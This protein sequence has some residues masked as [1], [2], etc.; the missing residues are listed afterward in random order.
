M[1]EVELDGNGLCLIRGKNGAGKSSVVK[2]L[3]FAF[4]GIGADD[5]VNNKVGKNTSVKVYG[6][7]GD[8]TFTVKRYRQD[9]EHKNNLYFFVNN[10][11]IAGATNTALQA[12]LES[13]L[14]FDYRSFLTITSFSS[15]MLMF[16][17][18]TDAERK[19]IFEKILQDLDIYNDYQKDTKEEILNMEVAIED[20]AHDIDKDER[21][22]EVIRKVM[23]TEESR[24]LILEQKR[25]ERIEELENDRHELEKKSR[26]SDRLKGKRERYN[27]AIFK[28]ELWLEKNMNPT[29]E[30]QDIDNEVYMLTMKE[31][32]LGFDDCPVCSTKLTPAHR[33]KEMNKIKKRM[34]ELD[35]ELKVLESFQ[36]K[37]MRVTD[38]MNDLLEN[39]AVIDYKLVRYETIPAKIEKLDD[40][41]DEAKSRLEDPNEAVDMWTSKL[42]KLSKKIASAS[43]RIAVLEG[44]LLYWKEVAQ[45]FSKQGIPNIIITRALTMLER[46]A[47]GYMDTLT[48]GAMSLRLT[49]MTKTKKGAIRNKIGIEV[50]SESGVTR[51]DSYSGGE[52]Q[53]L[54]I[55]LLLALRDVAEHNKGI[56]LNCLFLDEV[57][58]LSLDEEGIE[59]VL[60]VLRTKKSAVDSIFVITPKQQMLH[61]T[62]VTFDTVMTVEKKAGFSTVEIKES[63]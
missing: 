26:T 52:R 9:A 34:K 42:R 37:R 1:T 46:C 35:K 27:N 10:E 8:D 53:R 54:N 6:E 50:V 30:I 58:D 38:V 24:A 36:D 11:P 56:K 59:E 47:N 39:V 61:N 41:I 49:G 22:L 43:K 57:L 5:V 45:G 51:F 44:E 33:K 4:F 31:G 28:L 18:A 63:L 2:A 60:Q 7:N 17:S 19:G 21:E 12:K 13:Y 32:D 20:L 23:E 16:A 48:S 40:K 25:K 29:E 14:G 55:A 62:G 3:L 15:D